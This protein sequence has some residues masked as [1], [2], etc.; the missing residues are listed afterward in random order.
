MIRFPPEKPGAITDKKQ[1]EGF[2]TVTEKK[3]KL[4]G[5][6]LSRN[7]EAML[8]LGLEEKRREESEPDADAG[9]LLP[10]SLDPLDLEKT[11]LLSEK[12][13]ATFVEGEDEEVK[14]RAG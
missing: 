8:M 13:L 6:N 2:V 3:I 1:R 7:V 9:F 14:W 5:E 4:T 12:T 10:V 11:D